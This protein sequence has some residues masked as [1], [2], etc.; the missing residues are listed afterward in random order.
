MGVW[1]FDLFGGSRHKWSFDWGGGH[2]KPQLSQHQCGCNPRTCGADML[3]LL[4]KHA[5]SISLSTIES[6]RQS[7]GEWKIRFWEFDHEVHHLFLNS[8]LS[9][10]QT[11]T[12]FQMW[13]FHRNLFF[14]LGDVFFAWNEDVFGCFW[15]WLVELLHL[16]RTAGEDSK[17]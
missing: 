7:L 5:I 3:G 10:H 1:T 2:R 16:K 8:G 6:K 15:C 13:K 4:L 9:F 11:H 14:D 17:V 12:Y